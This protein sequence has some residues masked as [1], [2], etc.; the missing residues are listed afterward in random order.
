MTRYYRER[1]RLDNALQSIIEYSIPSG[2][3]NVPNGS[4]T[5]LQ[6]TNLTYEISQDYIG[7]P[8]ADSPFVLHKRDRTDAPI[9]SGSQTTDWNHFGYMAKSV[10]NYIAD[11]VR[12][13]Y[14][15]HVYPSSKSDLQ[16]AT[17]VLARTNPS[18]PQVNPG[19]LIQDLVELPQMLLNLGNNLKNKEPPLRLPPNS[20]KSAAGAYLGI[21]FGW[22]PLFEDIASLLDVY[23]YIDRRNAELHALFEKKGGAHHRVSFGSPSASEGPSMDLAESGGWIGLVRYKH[24]AET[25]SKVWATVRWFPT[26]APGWHPNDAE[27]LALAKKVVTGAT[28]SGA[29][30]AAW[31]VIP[32]TW[33]LGWVI[34]VRSFVL[35]NGNTI[36]AASS[37][38]SIMRT[39]DTTHSFSD[40]ES[41][42]GFVHSTSGTIRN[43]TKQR[44]IYSGTTFGAFLP[45][46]DAGR[47][48]VLTALTVQRLR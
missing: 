10:T 23:K 41:T 12:L 21:S 33:L 40:F 17:E 25:K 32:W 47:L 18:R 36:A 37:P 11:N 16:I 34:N 1:T 45:H 48:S 2:S 14:T 39:W 30:V 28:A 29:F 7:R 44:F 15:G 24:T 20:G 26:T 6:I 8:V 3:G 4:G 27:V 42:Q 19:A 43:T 46:L 13:G 31:D 35:A 38:V 5:Q 9:I 22:A